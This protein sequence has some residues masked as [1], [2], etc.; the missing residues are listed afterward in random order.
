MLRDAPP[1]HPFHSRAR[2][3]LVA[4][5]AGVGEVLRTARIWW[6]LPMAAVG[7]AGMITIR[8]LW[9]GP[10]FND[11]FGLDPVDRGNLLL[12]LTVGSIVSLIVYGWLGRALR[13]RKGIVVVGSALYAA[14][15]AAIAAL[16]APSLWLATTL[17]I[18]V[19]M[20]GAVYPVLLA[21]ARSMFPD[22]LVGR[23]ITSLNLASF[24]GIAIIQAATGMIMVQFAGEPG[25]AA[26]A[27]AYRAVF[28]ALA[29][30]IGIAA[31]CYMRSE[32][33]PQRTG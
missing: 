3:G 23:T 29:L 28:A 8:G 31:L 22:R 4:A 7:Y 1:G 16:P 10:Y 33:R 32:D 11:V 2:E 14:S 13:T 17:L 21:H 12:L 18:L 6:I 20:F 5:A 24:S 15:F 9:G 26:P 19:S 25:T 27:E 30:V